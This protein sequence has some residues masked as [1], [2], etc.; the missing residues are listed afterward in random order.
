[1]HIIYNWSNS[2]K[3]INRSIAQRVNLHQTEEIITFIHRAGG[4]GGGG[5]KPSKN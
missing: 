4:D 2:A 1:M 3:R 5:E